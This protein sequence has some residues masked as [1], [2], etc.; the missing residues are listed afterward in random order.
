MQFRNLS[1]VNVPK[2]L[3]RNIAKE[4]NVDKEL[5][6][7]VEDGILL[8]STKTLKVTINKLIERG[9]SGEQEVVLG[10]NTCGSISIYPCPRCTIGFLTI[11]Y[12]HEICHAWLLEY[13]ED[14]YDIYDTCEFCEAFAQK[15]YKI[16]GGKAT[17]RLCG[18]HHLSI[19][20]AVNKFSEFKVYVSQFVTMSSSEL[21]HKFWES[22]NQKIKTIE[23][24]EK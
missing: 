17:G 3:W 18:D 23:I 14:I 11:T 12:L 19:D 24:R 22:P 9:G 10:S 4:M 5:P 8:Y 6:Q 2:Y 7:A 15:S 16:L 1:S 21:Q 20:Q 13:H